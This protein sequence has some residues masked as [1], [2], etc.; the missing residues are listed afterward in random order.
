[1]SSVVQIDNVTKRF[2]KQTALDKVTL[3]IPSGVVFA[4]LGENGAGKTTTIRTLLGLEIP[5]EGAST[6]LELD[7]RKQGVKIRRKTGFVPEAPTLYEWMTVSEIGWFTSGFYSE[8]F[9]KK[10]YELCESFDLPLKKKL[11]HLSKGM[12][13]K[14]SLSLAMAHEPELLILDEPTSGL[15]TLVRR[16]FLESMVDVAAAGRTVL[17]SSHQIPEVERVADIVAIMNKGQ[18]LVCESLES[19]KARLEQWTVTLT[20]D[21]VNLPAIDSEVLLE[22]RDQRRIRLTLSSPPT[23][24]LCQLREHSCVAE[25]QVNVPSLEEI[26]VMYLR[27]SE[28]ARNPAGGSLRESAAHKSTVTNRT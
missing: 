10:Y 6:V 20:G 2:G 25:V 22:E 17:L 15:D 11:K 21:S 4:L 3:E 5:N 28:L 23:E 7:S 14:V 24:T 19:L 16:S 13:A 8:G 1:M 12:K 26:F 27:R 18:V 9:L